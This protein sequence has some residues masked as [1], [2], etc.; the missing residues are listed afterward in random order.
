MQELSA[1]EVA[2][3][4]AGRQRVFRKLSIMDR[5]ALIMFAAR[6][7]ACDD[8]EMVRE[9]LRDHCNGVFS[10]EAQRGEDDV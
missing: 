3:F 8:P 7:R 1:E 9:L 10:P 4:A 6:L 5:E 2:M